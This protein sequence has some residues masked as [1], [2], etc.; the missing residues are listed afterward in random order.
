MCQSTNNSRRE[1]M[2]TTPGASERQCGTS[3]LVTQRQTAQQNF[4]APHRLNLD[5]FVIFIVFHQFTDASFANHRL[6]RSQR[7]L[8]I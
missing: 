8:L 5:S 3:V 1:P 6:T 2:S 4:N 7:R